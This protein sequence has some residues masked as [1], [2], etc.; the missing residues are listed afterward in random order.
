MN[1][2]RVTKFAFLFAV[3][4]LIV[5]LSACDQLVSILTSG[6]MPDDEMSDD[7]GM[8]TGLPMDIAMYRSW[9]GVELEAP[10]ATFTQPEDSGVAHGA[11]TRTVYINS[12]GV[13]TLQDMSAETFP[14]GT[15]IVKDIMDDANT[16]IWRVAVMWK[17]DDMAYADH[18]GWKYVQYQRESEAADLMAVAGDGT[19]RGSNGCHGCHSK[20]NTED[21]PGKD[22]VFVQLP[23]PGDGMTDDGMADD[24][25]TDDDMA[26]DGMT[27]DD[28]ADDGMT[29][30]GDGSN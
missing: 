20:V 24:G 30:D 29:D 16:F 21:V 28:M 2:S 7:M 26:D 17:L 15:T 4:A 25:M 22:S 12:P 13:S 14:S 5:G 6:D 8:M 19:E 18:N 11:G 3:A 27:D 9:T 10:P 1:T 23:M